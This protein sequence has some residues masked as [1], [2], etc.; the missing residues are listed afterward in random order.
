MKARKTR[1]IVRA[2]RS[3]SWAVEVQEGYERVFVGFASSKR[4]AYRM[5]KTFASFTQMTK[6][7]GKYV[8]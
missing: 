4:E 2:A 6:G 3:H 8:A 1:I 7:G 5:G